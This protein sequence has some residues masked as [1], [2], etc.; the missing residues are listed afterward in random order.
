MRKWKRPLWYPAFSTRQAGSCCL[1]VGFPPVF[2]CVA[3][4]REEESSAPTRHRTLSPPP[5]QHPGAGDGD[6]HCSSGEEHETELHSGPH[7]ARNSLQLP[8]ARGGS[9]QSGVPSRVTQG[10]SQPRDT[11]RSCCHLLS[12]CIHKKLFNHITHCHVTYCQTTTGFSDP[13]FYK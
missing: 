4:S 5:R 10:L 8:T 6:P 1:R 7:P 13:L 9:S 3:Q 2:S 12:S 11:H